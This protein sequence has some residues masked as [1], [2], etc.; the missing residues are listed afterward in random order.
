MGAKSREG[1]NRGVGAKSRTYGM[2]VRVHEYMAYCMFGVIWQT[3]TISVVM[4]VLHL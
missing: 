4:Y 2:C 1:L 3:I